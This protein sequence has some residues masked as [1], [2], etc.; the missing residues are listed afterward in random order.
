MRVCT[1]C[2][3]PNPAG[4][5]FCVNP[6]C[7]TYLGWQT[8]TFER[9][10]PTGSAA[11]NPPASGGMGAEAKQPTSQARFARAQTFGVRVSLDPKDVT[12]EPGGVA[13]ATLRIQNTGTQ[14]EE[15][16]IGVMGPAGNFTTAAPGVLNVFPG[17]EQ[18]AELRFSP[19]RAPAS[20]PGWIPFTAVAWSAR[21]QALKDGAQGTVTVGSFTELHAELRPESS[22]GRRPTTHRMVST[23]AGNTP[24]DVHVAL[25]DPEGALRFDPVEARA[26][27]QPGAQWEAPIQVAGARRWFGRTQPNAFTALVSSAENGAPINLTGRRNQVPILPWWIPTAAAV[28]I[29]LVIAVLSLLPTDKVPGIKGLTEAAAIQRLTDE[30]YRAVAI[31][32]PDASVPAGFAIGTDPASGSELRGGES[33]QLFI[34]LGPCREEC[35]IEVPNVEGLELAEAQ[36]ALRTAGFNVARVNRVPSS[37]LAAGLVIASKPDAGSS[38]PRGSAVVLKVSSGSPAPSAPPSTTGGGN[39]PDD[40][41]PGPKP[42]T[43][44]VDLVEVPQVVAHPRTTAVDELEQAE[45]QVRIVE[46]E[47]SVVEAGKA[48]GTD[49]KAGTKLKKGTTVTLFISSGS[50]NQTGQL[51]SHGSLTVRQTWTADVDEGIEGDP[52]ADFWFEA[53]TETA[54]Y[55]TPYN[56]ATLAAVGVVEP[57]PDAC[58]DTDLRSDRIDVASLQIGSVVCIRTDQGRL[59]VVTVDQ[60]PGPSPGTI[61][62]SFSTYEQGG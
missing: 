49:P 9:P 17:T 52:G 31:M 48:I 14:V 40:G 22:R 43:Q 57:T 53:E 27:I 7:R 28:V 12:V 5:E 1:G 41:R 62:I 46:R 39:G 37:E 44:A 50:A 4:A 13:I 8:S 16:R 32:Q 36:D 54:R 38:L 19:L 18:T 6:D 35:P 42:D 10:G 51:H 21:H 24:I 60:P 29:A 45:L 58:A 15:F 20:R 59:S 34:S 25:S 56:G 47:S 61:E 3:H 55:I 33:V 30:G 2:G 26:V 23:N 11:G